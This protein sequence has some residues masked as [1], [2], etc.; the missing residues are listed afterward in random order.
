M[1]RY[2][3][4]CIVV[5]LALSALLQLSAQQA[6]TPKGANPLQIALTLDDLPAQGQKPPKVT[7]LQIVESL[8]ATLK[9]EKLPRCMGL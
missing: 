6:G 1:R 3:F 4:P 7:R 8:L 5:L 2:A 9:Q